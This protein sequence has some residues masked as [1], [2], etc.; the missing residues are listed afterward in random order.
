MR[1]EKGLYTQWKNHRRNVPVPEGFAAGV[2]THLDHRPPM[3]EDNLEDI[4]TWFPGRLLQWSGAVGLVFIG[5]LRIVY[6]A[7]SLLWANPL[8]PK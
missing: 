4:A 8:M 5:L 7:A 1:K 6:I 2:M 3:V